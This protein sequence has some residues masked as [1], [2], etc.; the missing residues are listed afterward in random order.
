M[1]HAT[2]PFD[3]GVN[4]FKPLHHEARR[5]SNIKVGD[6]IVPI[7]Y[8]PDRTPTNKV[9]FAGFDGL[10]VHSKN[11]R[12]RTIEGTDSIGQKVTKTFAEL[13]LP[14]FVIPGLRWGR[15]SS[16]VCTVPH[17]V[18]LDMMR[19]YVNTHR[20]PLNRGPGP[21]PFDVVAISRNKIGLDEFSK[22]TPWDGAKVAS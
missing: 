19:D 22:R 4:V 14:R 13:G 9:E 1:H 18:A 12:T 2:I 8:G 5:A 16:Q 17:A 10:T 20:Q 3:Y 15:W 21:G 11:M 7:Q 6:L